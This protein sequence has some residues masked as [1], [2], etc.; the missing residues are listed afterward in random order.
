MVLGA[1]LVGPHVT[2]LVHELALAA[3]AGLTLDAMV[4]TIHAHPTLSEAVGEAALGR[5]RARHA[6][7][8]RPVGVARGSQAGLAEGEGCRRRRQFRATGALLDEL[9]LHTVCEEARCPNKGECFAAGTATFLI[10]GDACTRGCRFCSVERRRRVARRAG[11]GR[12]AR[13]GEAAARL[14]LRHVVVTSV[15]RDDLPD[16][17]AAH[18]AATIRAV[19]ERVAGRDGRG[20][21]AGLRRRRRRRCAPCSPSAPTC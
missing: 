13:V 12:A 8:S 9:A 18:F 21:G 3:H 11:P 15:T 4:D 7:A 16:G 17:G 20:A 5:R 2:E 6:L 19:R 10:L 14:G 1:S